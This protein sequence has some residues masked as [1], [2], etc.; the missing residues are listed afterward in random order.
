[1]RRFGNSSAE[2]PEIMEGGFIPPRPRSEG[3]ARRHATKS[4]TGRSVRALTACEQYD[5]AMVRAGRIVLFAMLGAML[6]GA[7]A[8]G[9][10]ADQKRASVDPYWLRPFFSGVPVSRGRDNSRPH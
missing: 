4:P 10:S 8:S 7:S 2:G 5:G 3:G 6:L 9:Q 1:M